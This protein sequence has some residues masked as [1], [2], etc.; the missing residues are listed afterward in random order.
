MKEVLSG[1]C[2]Y[3]NKLLFFI[4]GKE[5]LSYLG[6]G[7]FDTDPLTLN[8]TNTVAIMPHTCFNYVEIPK[9]YL[10][11]DIHTNERGI[12]WTL[13]S[14][15]KLAKEFSYHQLLSEKDMTFNKAGGGN[16]IVKLFL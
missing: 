8:F 11:D 5:N 9:S 16:K 14:R 12:E 4:T 3:L 13:T 10:K 1:H 2:D 6:Y 15:E 7:D